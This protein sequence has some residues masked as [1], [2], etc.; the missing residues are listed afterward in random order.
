MRQRPIFKNNTA[1]LLGFVI[2]IVLVIFKNNP[3]GNGES[4]VPPYDST[5]TKTV[6]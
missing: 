5:M 4:G 2:V 6:I 3:M 1:S